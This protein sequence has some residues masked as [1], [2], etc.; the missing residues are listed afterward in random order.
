[1]STYYLGS[2][3]DPATGSAEL[4]EVLAPSQPRSLVELAEITHVHILGGSLML[5]LLCHLLSV[6]KISDGTRTGLYLSSFA[7]FFLTFACPW[8]IILVSSGFAY[9]YGPSVVLFC[10]CLTALCVIPI[11]E[12]WFS[13]RRWQSMPLPAKPSVYE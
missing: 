6:C 7:G 3:S 11:R 9:L 12:M 8:L 4:D 2:K 1:M 10:L 5:F 13:D